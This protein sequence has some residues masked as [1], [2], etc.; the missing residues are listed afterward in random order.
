MIPL[1]ASVNTMLPPGGVP[2]GRLVTCA[3]AWASTSG[4]WYFSVAHAY[5]PAM[6]C[7]TFAGCVLCGWNP[8]GGAGWNTCT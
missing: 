4:H 8:T 5:Q 1:P 3:M 2:L 6:F 7:G